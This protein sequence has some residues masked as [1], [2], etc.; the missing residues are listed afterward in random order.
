MH[1]QTR[2]AVVEIHTQTRIAGKPRVFALLL[3][4]IACGSN[5]SPSSSGASGTGG[6]VSGTGG[7]GTPGGASTTGGASGTSAGGTSPGGT[8]SGGTAAG[9]TGGASGTAGN[10]T[11]GAGGAPGGAGGTSGAGAT[12]GDAG[13]GGTTGGTGGMPGG[14]GGTGGVTGTA[15]FTVTSTLASQMNSAAPTT[16][17]IVTWSVNVSGLSSAAIE[18]GPTTAYGMRAPV[19]LAEPMYRT[20]L[21]GM[22]PMTMYHFRVVASAGTTNYASNDY[23]ITTGAPTTA[24]SVSRFQEM[25][26]MA[27]KRGFII[28]SY[29]MGNGTAVPFI[30]DA[31]GTIVWWRTGGPSGG[32]ARAVMSA[33]G[34]NMWMTTAN[35]TGQPIQRV[36][37]DGLDAQTYSNRVGSHDITPVSGATMAFLEYGESDCNSVYEIDPSG[38]ATEVFETQGVVT[39]SGCHANALRYSQKE[40]V[41]TVSDVRQ[42]IFVVSRTGQVQ[43]RLSQRTMGGNMAWGGTQHGHQLLDSSI[44]IFANVAGGAGASDAIEY[45]LQGQEIMRY[46]GGGFSG[47]LGDVQRL[48]GG[49]TLITYSNAGIIREIDP[50]KNVVLEIAG[51]GMNRFGYALWRESL[52]GLPPDILQ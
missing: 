3:L 43:W 42:D 40:N 12:G 24:V 30:L 45:N 23:T 44:L 27:R 17:G 2:E 38:N 1:D 35:N 16:V 47:N 13:A 31:D 39:A 26:A 25:N 14:T 6:A 37:M 32:I 20:L 51:G 29:W 4:A 5:E 41:Y 48:P 9:P 8:S 34:K 10:T 22:K 19:D 50:Q 36:S 49:N 28:T 52:Y 21:L 11:G 46:T 7:T 18:F 33:D 15:T